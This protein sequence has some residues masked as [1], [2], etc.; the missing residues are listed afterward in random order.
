MNGDDTIGTEIKPGLKNSIYDGAF[1]Q[2]MTVLTSGIFLTGFALLLGANELVIGILASIPFVAQLTQLVS[3]FIIEQRG[4]RKKTC[5]VFASVNRIA[6]LM[7]FSILLLRNPEQNPVS[8]WILLGATVIS[9]L[10]GSAGGVA[11]LSWMADLVPEEIRGR[12]FAKRNMILAIVGVGITLLA[13]KYLDLWKRS[14]T[15][16]ELHGFLSLFLVAVICG[17]LSLVFLK[18]IPDLEKAKPEKEFYNF[19]KLIKIPFKDSNFLRFALFSTAWSFSVYI[20]APF[21]VVYMLKDLKM[22]YGLL[23]LVNI[24]GDISTILALPFWGK[25]SDRF[26]SKPV[27]SLTTM[28]TSL[29]PM[30][31]VLTVSPHFVFIIMILQVNA[32]LFWSGLNLNSNNLLLKLSPKEN[33]SIY[34]ATF[35]ALTGLTT[36]IAPILGGLLATKLRGTQLNLGFARVY[37]LQFLFLI[38][39]T[40]RLVSRIF[41][42]KIVE[43]K[44]KPMGRMIR[45]L[46]KL[47]T[48]NV[49]KGFEPL[50]NYVYL[51]TSRIIDFIEK[52]NDTQ[53]N[54]KSK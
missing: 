21:F 2:I 36:A 1:C 32:G 9:Y 49:T 41:L 13:G 5:L 28:A 48:I 30:L 54:D 43:P 22:S 31:W 18:K 29:L 3:S 27:L 51:A 34:L 50:L 45:A 35:A 37:D 39:G 10:F 16:M 52:K 17:I 24:V 12:F 19:W 46:G 23:A 20:T 53:I 40:L 25:L 26:G 11:W 4:R 6:W 44:E 8:I 15:V 47:G 42:K 38:S 7:V 14:G 33:N